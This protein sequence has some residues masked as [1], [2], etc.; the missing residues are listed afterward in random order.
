MCGF[1]ARSLVCILVLGVSNNLAEEER[2]LVALYVRTLHVIILC[3]G[4]LFV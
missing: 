3:S 4:R 2:K 1:C